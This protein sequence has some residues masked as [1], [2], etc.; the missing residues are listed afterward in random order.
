MRVL[1]L[2][3]GSCSVGKVAKRMGCEVFSVDFEPFKGIS[4]FGLRDI[5]E[6][7]PS[8]VP[9]T[10]DVIWAS[11]PCQSYSLAAIKTHRH[12]HDRSPKTEFAAKSDRLVLN[13]LKIIRSF[14]DTVFYMENPRATLQYMPFMLGIDRAV[15]WYCKYGDRA[16]KP[17]NIFTNN[18][19]TLSNPDGWQPRPVC[20]K[21]NPHCHHERAPRGSQTG[22][23]G[24]TDHFERSRVPAALCKEVLQ[25]AKRRI[26]LVQ[27]VM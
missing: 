10:P 6:F 24:K 1:E 15:V 3:A 22:T 27:S 13:T 26:E 11:P 14:P 7:H 16:A 17:T 12:Q 5:E 25:A 18:L 9:W 2:F 4:L 8:E 20:V 19:R 21:N 23:Q